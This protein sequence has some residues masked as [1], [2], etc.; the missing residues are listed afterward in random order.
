MNKLFNMISSFNSKYNCI[1]I[2][3]KKHKNARNRDKII[4]E[5]IRQTD[6]DINPILV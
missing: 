4:Y 6:Y 3:Y 2:Y 5:Q 1:Y